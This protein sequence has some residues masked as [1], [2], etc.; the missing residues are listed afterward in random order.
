MDVNDAQKA[1]RQETGGGFQ[2]SYTVDDSLVLLKHL[3]FL[4]DIPNF[5]ISLKKKNEKKKNIFSC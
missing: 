2:N 5:S 3:S 4:A 1:L